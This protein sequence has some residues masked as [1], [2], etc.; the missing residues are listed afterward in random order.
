MDKDGER[1]QTILAEVGREAL[2]REG[3]AV[4]ASLGERRLAREFCRRAVAAPTREELA[5]LLLEYI[6]LRRPG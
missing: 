1:D 4:L 2:L 6:L 5:E 3:R